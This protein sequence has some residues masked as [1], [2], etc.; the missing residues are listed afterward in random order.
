MTTDDGRLDAAGE[1][2]R[3]GQV[4]AQPQVRA[5][6]L[7]R[8]AERDDD[9]GVWLQELFRLD[10]R[11]VFEASAPGGPLACCCA[12]RTQRGQ[13]QREKQQSHTHHGLIGMRRPPSAAG[14]TVH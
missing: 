9:D 11:V 12:D 7:E 4:V 3:Q 2:L 10:P 8:G 6:L 13:R 1:I 5:V 14:W